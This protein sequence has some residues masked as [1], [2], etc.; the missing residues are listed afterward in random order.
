MDIGS[1]ISQIKKYDV[2]T[3]QVYSGSNSHQNLLL[4][5]FMAEYDEHKDNFIN[6]RKI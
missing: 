2:H 4:Y 6:V 3:F 5:F 1:F